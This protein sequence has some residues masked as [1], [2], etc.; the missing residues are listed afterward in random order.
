MVTVLQDEDG[1]EEVVEGLHVEV[2]RLFIV[3]CRCGACRRAG[4]TFLDGC[5]ATSRVGAED[6]IML[7]FGKSS[8][9]L[10]CLDCVDSVRLLAEK[11]VMTG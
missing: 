4:E 11:V 9:S 1:E 8:I 7:S 3:A 6:H 5:F 2:S 10:W